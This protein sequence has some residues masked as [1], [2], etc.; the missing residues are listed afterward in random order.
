MTTGMEFGLLGPLVVPLVVRR[1]GLAVP[2]QMGKQRV[3]LATLLLNAGRVVPVDEL[4]E[5]MWESEPPP[6][7]RVTLQNY[8]KRLRRALDDIDRARIS[9]W[10]GG[11]WISVQACELDVSRFLALRESARESARAGSWDRAATELRTALEL[12]RGEPLADVPSEL[13]AQREVP[14]LAEMR[15]QALEELVDADLRLGRHADVIAE[16]RHLTGAYPLREHLHA[17]LMLALYRNGCQ[18]EALAVYQHARRVLIEELGTEPAAE[19]RQ[20]HQRILAADATLAV[21]APR[22]L[23]GDEP[24][25]VYW[26]A[27]RRRSRSGRYC[28]AP[29]RARRR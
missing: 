19:L 29:R 22:R 2:V 12:W 26:T 21:P 4:A 7:A 8:V 18:G 27:P 6:S 10:P 11:Y 20:I 28:L 17:L 15:L 9:T 3:L 1:G 16:L 13:L 14:R 23:A 25:P 24:G 5:V